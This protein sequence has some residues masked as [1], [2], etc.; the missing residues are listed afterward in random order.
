[1]QNSRPLHISLFIIS[2]IT[3]SAIVWTFIALLRKHLLN[4]EPYTLSGLFM[5]DNFF[6]LTLMLIPVFWL[7]LYSVIGSY[8]GSVYKKSRLSELT[9]TFIES[10]FGSIIL[11][12][13]LF[14]NDSER[15]YTYFYTT[16]F[17]LLFLQTIITYIGRFIIINTAKRHLV[18]GKFFFNTLIVGN[19]RKAYDAF[20]EIKKNHSASG[21]NIVGFIA[22]DK[23][24]KN[25]LGR[26]LN[27][28]GNIETM[29]NIIHEKKVERVIIAL[30]KTESE[31]TESIISRLS[32]KDV[33]VKMVP[34]TFQILYSPVKTENILGAVLID[35]D[36]GLMP[37]W[38]CNIKRLLDIIISFISLIILSPVLVFTALRTKFSSGGP[39]I[40][41]Q[42]RTGYKGKTFYIHKFRSMYMNAEKD[43]PALSSEK[44]PRITP[45][46]RTMRK[47]RLDELP[48]LWNILKGEMSFVGPRPERQFYIDHLNQRTPYFRYLLKVKPGLT[49]W[50]MVRFGYASTIEEMIERMKYDLV[51]IE[52]ISL[53]LDL[54]IMVY[55]LRI[56]L[57]GKGM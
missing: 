56:I 50:G 6:P 15:H 37:A 34:E 27:C 38:Q 12:F 26:W 48:Q 54:K 39:V 44:D 9:V 36:T 30:D 35:I 14:L 32:E 10:F 3:A 18:T 24:Q 7:I 47:W 19:S 33:E 31:L 49:S 45:W 55:S 40:F 43:G 41:S 29:E 46:G 23:T 42:E 16:F 53:L 11:L 51:Y 20:K 57:S 2:D 1:M 22:S 8:N 17:A 25:G 21:Y 52:N 28:L 13:V 4:E 5:Q